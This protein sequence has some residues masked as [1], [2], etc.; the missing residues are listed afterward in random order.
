MR[1]TTKHINKRALSHNLKTLADLAPQSKVI[2]VVKANA[3][4]HEATQVIEALTRADL[5]AVAAI[6]EAIALRGAGAIQPILLL[7]GAFEPSE[8]TLAYQNDFELMISTPQQLDWLLASE[9]TFSRV[10]FKL[11]TGMGRLGF[12]LAHAQRALDALLSRYSPHHIVLTSHFS[13]SDSPNRSIT[14]EQIARFDTVAERYPNC[15]QSLC[16][17]AGILSYPDAHRNYI[18]PGIAL[19]G[20]SPF[21]TTFADDHN[22]RPVMT[23]KTR[24]LSVKY[25]LQ[26]QPI[27]Y[28]QTYR[29]PEAGYIAICE[30]GYADGYSRFIPSG[31]PIVIAGREYRTAGRVAMDMLAV[32]VDEYV[33]VGDEVICWGDGLPIERICEAAQTIP[34]QLLTTVTERPRKVIE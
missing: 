8:V 7:E 29:L 31:A 23:L 18:R 10:W 9:Y 1:A 26:G 34:H 6:E 5:L 22:L 13:D 3:Y 12:P 16:N 4:G 2:A 30:I 33:K 27:G 19:Y 17:S 20:A 21:D 25:F 32:V 24:V 15:E 11:D 28:G 14:N